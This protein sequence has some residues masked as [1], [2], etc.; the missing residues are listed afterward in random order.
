MMRELDDLYEY[1]DAWE[2]RSIES[3]DLDD[4]ILCR[5]FMEKIKEV[6]KKYGCY[7]CKHWH[8][9]DGD[10]HYD[11]EIVSPNYCSKRYTSLWEKDYE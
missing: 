4:I 1:V 10:C 2:R 9:R 5:R 8:W 7:T 3:G 6:D 11:H